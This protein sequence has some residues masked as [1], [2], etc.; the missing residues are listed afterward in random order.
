MGIFAKRSG[1]GF[2][3]SVIVV[4]AMLLSAISACACAHHLPTASA[5]KDCHSIQHSNEHARSDDKRS[6][7]HGE[8]GKATNSNGSAD[9]EVS[10]LNDGE[11]YSFE[12][13]CNCGEGDSITA[14]TFRNESVHQTVAIANEID[15]VDRKPS[16][17]VLTTQST[18]GFS[19]TQNSYQTFFRYRSGPSRAPPRL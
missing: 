6:L 2:A 8:H 7:Q 14:V 19:S 9:G 5:A 11:V 10:A 13:P 3:V 16:E 18:S 1:S 17:L 15:A 4:A 12:I